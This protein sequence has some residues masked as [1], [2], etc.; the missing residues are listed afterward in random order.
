MREGVMDFALFVMLNGVLLIRPEE[1]TPGGGDLRLYLIVLGPTLVAAG[2]KLL[3][4]LR[5]SELRKQPIS[6]CVLGFWVA[7]ALSQLVR[8]QIGLAIDFFDSFGKTV[9]YYFLLVSVIYTP[10]RL[11]TFLG[12]LVVLIIAMSTLGLLQYHGVVDIEALRT[13]ERKDFFDPEKGEFAVIT[14]RRGTGIYSDPNDLCLI[15]VTGSLCALYRALTANAFFTRLLWLLPM[16]QFGYALTLTQSRGGLIGLAVAVFTLCCSSL[17]WRR[18]IL[19]VAA[20]LPAAP[21]LVGSRQTSI[22][23]DKDDTSTGRVQIWSDG[24]MAM[25]DNPV[26]GIGVGEYGGAVG[27]VAHNSFV[28]AYVETG[29]LGGSLYAEA[30][31]LAVLVLTLG[32]GPTV[33]SLSRMRSFLLSMVAGYI[34]GTFSLSRNYVMPTYMILGLAAIW[35]SLKERNRYPRYSFDRYGIARI[36]RHGTV[37]LIGLW[38]LTILLL[39]LSS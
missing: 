4:A 9:L 6:V 18:G 31:I 14:Q 16:G 19:L 38:L 20:L 8:G 21:F 27:H 23:L 7:G 36:V 10:D 29:I 15:L 35:I 39:R 1:L 22:G 5:W 11:R 28:Q 32:K 33:D 17:G 25:K 30:F 34:G 37:G 3:A 2:P 24:L 12:W 26:S 13:G